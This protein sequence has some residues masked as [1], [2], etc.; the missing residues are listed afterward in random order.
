MNNITYHKYKRKHEAVEKAKEMLNKIEKK[1]GDFELSCYFQLTG[2]REIDKDEVKF[3]FRIHWK[4]LIKQMEQQ[5]LN[6]EM[7]V[8]G[9][10]NENYTEGFC[11]PTF[12]EAVQLIEAL[13]DVY[14]FIC[15]YYPE[16]ER[17]KSEPIV[18]KDTTTRG[19]YLEATNY[20]AANPVHG[21][22]PKYFAVLEDGELKEFY[23]ATISLY[24][25]TLA[26]SIY[27]E[28]Q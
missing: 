27:F 7:L 6:N 22:K 24:D 12:K 21:F 19:K 25:L 28:Y 10:W 3:F 17:K 8:G 23:P 1:S 14:N 4:A 11:V 9:Q 26:T 5:L 2:V 15:N 20:F 18:F 16:I 13:D